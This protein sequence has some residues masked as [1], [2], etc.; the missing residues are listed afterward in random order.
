LLEGLVGADVLQTVELV[1]QDELVSDRTTTVQ[2]QVPK[3]KSASASRW[4]T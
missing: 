1:K 3:Y 4:M 2:G